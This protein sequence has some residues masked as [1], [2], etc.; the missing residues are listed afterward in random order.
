MKKLMDEIPTNKE[1]ET[2]NFALSY[3]VINN[4]ILKALPDYRN[5]Q[6]PTKIKK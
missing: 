4:F 3:I 5:G 1:C 6:D 2:Y